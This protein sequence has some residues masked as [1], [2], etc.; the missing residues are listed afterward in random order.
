MN[1]PT[2]LREL[3]AVLKEIQSQILIF[4]LDSRSKH[5]NELAI[6]RHLENLL[7]GKL[8]GILHAEVEID[9]LSDAELMSLMRRKPPKPK[10]PKKPRAKR[11]TFKDLEEFM[12]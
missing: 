7:K 12:K 8:S 1:A 5:T 11:F 4:E 2:L 3:H 9:S 6:L 10:T